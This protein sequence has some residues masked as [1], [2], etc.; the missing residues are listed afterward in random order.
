VVKLSIKGAIVFIGILVLGGLGVSG[1]VFLNYRLREENSDELQLVGLW[2]DLEQNTENNPKH[3]ADSNFLIEWLSLQEINGSYIAETNHTRFNLLVP[4][5]YKI[6][7]RVLFS[8]LVGAESYNVAL[9][10]NGISQVFFERFASA[11]PFPDESFFSTSSIY[12]SNMNSATYFEI[13]AYSVMGDQFIILPD[14]SNQLS[15]E[16][17]IQ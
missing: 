17:V 2:D 4:G 14:P 6:S 5:L 12:I 10:I 11:T 16:Y 15:I 3:N 8:S 13:Y 9:S 7:L 1:G